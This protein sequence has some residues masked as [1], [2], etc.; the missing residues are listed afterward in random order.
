LHDGHRGD[1]RTFEYLTISAP[2]FDDH[3]LVAWVDLVDLALEI[4]LNHG[5]ENM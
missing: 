3:D 4:L 5:E 1:I 2:D